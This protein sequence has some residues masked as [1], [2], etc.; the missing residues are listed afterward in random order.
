MAK[1]S[2]ETWAKRVEQWKDSGLSGPEFAREVGISRHS[3]SWWKWRLRADARRAADPEAA[4]RRPRR[5]RV[6]KITPPITFV[7][8]PAPT[9]RETLEVVL[10]TGV[11]IRV[12]SEFDAGAVA[13]L[14][15]ALGE[16]Q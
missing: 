14:V 1:T 8:M 4:K 2:R 6:S 15:Q 16:R 7:E 5:K 3:L 10:P 11:R 9:L 13:R 12:P